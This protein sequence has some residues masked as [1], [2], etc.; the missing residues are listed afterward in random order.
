[1]DVAN[2]FLPSGDEDGEYH[3]I[4]YACSY[5]EDDFGKHLLI[6]MIFYDVN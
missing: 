2:Q 1:M 5:T 6:S 4:C 3:N